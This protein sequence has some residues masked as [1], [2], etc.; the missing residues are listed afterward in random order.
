[1]VRDV[2]KYCDSCMTCKRSK[3]NNQCPYGLLNPLNVPTV[4]WEA[5]GIDFVG[6]LQES[7]DRDATYNSIT[8]VIDLLSGMVHLIPSRINYTA[9]E[10]AELVV[11][12]IYKL[13]GIPKYIISDRD[14][15]FNSTFWTHFHKLIGTKLCMS[16][17]Y[18]PESDGSTERAN[19]TVTQ[20]LRQ[21]V[22]PTQKDWVSKLPGY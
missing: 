7:R 1:M 9:K 14:V 11:S 21:C 6:P 15:V 16:S 13:H 10:V 12:E 19:Q 2:Q 8:V 22:R 20:M 4:P 17:A 18:H 5:I 3:P